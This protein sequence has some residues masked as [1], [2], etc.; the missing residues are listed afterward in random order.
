[1]MYAGFVEF[2]GLKELRAALFKETSQLSRR[3][4]EDI[5]A[6]L[7]QVVAAHERR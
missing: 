6:E 3:S 1:M 2:K 7:M 5:E 4:A